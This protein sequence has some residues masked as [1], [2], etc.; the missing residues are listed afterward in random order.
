MMHTISV[1]TLRSVKR[2]CTRKGKQVYPALGRDW[3]RYGLAVLLVVSASFSPGGR[4]QESAARGKNDPTPQ[5]SSI[6]Q[7]VKPVPFAEFTV[8]VHVEDKRFMVNGDFTL[9][10][11]SNG[12]DLSK[13]AVN[14]R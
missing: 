3:N 9:G 7:D 1:S 11:G 5:S 10:S 8:K 4:Q 6:G 2:D 13:D 12:I 14:L